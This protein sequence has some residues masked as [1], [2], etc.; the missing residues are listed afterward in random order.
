MLLSVRVHGN[1]CSFGESINWLG[2]SRN[3]HLA[4]LSG[5]KNVNSLWLSKEK[6]TSMCVYLGVAYTP[7]LTLRWHI[8]G[9]LLRWCLWLQSCRQIYVSSLG[10]WISRMWP[11]HIYNMNYYALVR[12]NRLGIHQTKSRVIKENTEW[13]LQRNTIQVKHI[14]AHTAYFNS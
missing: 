2:H 14:Y 11:M 9:C 8:M 6:S 13:D 5:S 12:S 7:L 4:V 1:S 10:E 3:N